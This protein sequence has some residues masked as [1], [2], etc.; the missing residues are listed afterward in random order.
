MELVAGDSMLNQY[1]AKDCWCN[2]HVKT[3]HWSITFK[4]SSCH[5][6]IDSKNKHPKT[7][8]TNLSGNKLI[9]ELK[10]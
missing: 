2:D 3:L 4:K 5:K 6:Q 9:K 7:K 10:N 8:G 1:S